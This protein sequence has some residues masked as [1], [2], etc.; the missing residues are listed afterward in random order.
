MG[1]DFPP[2]VKR[3][4]VDLSYNPSTHLLHRLCVCLLTRALL[5]NGS[6]AQQPSAVHDSNSNC[7][8]NAS[9]APSIVP[10][11][12]V[13]S[14][15][16]IVL[17]LPQSATD[18]TAGRP[19]VASSLFWEGAEHAFQAASREHNINGN[20]NSQYGPNRALQ[21]TGNVSPGLSIMVQVQIAS[22]SHGSMGWEPL[23]VNNASSPG[24]LGTPLCQTSFGL[25]LI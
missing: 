17:P 16:H 3:R 22:P 21:N 11:A 18:D 1:E 12:P 5:D 19:N 10:E 15:D 8:Y 2:V 23:V 25:I 24:N 9:I 13:F 6:A 14:R 4:M 20:F 7:A